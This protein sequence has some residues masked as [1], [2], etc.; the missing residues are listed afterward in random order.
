MAPIGIMLKILLPTN[1]GCLTH[2]KL[3][4]RSPLSNKLYF[5]TYTLLGFDVPYPIMKMEY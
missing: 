5:K 2:S 4:R 3:D 1:E